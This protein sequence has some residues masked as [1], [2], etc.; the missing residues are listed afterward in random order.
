MKSTQINRFVKLFLVALVVI[1][2]IMYLFYELIL[3][4]LR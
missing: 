2:I 3:S 1:F 4:N